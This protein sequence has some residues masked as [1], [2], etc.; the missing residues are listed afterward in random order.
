M[1]PEWCTIATFSWF[2][3]SI[4]FR[5]SKAKL[6]KT[7]ETTRL[8][9][10][11]LCSHPVTRPHGRCA[12]PQQ[13]LSQLRMLSP[14]PSLRS[15]PPPSTAVVMVTGGKGRSCDGHVLLRPDLLSPN[16]LRGHYPG[17]TFQNGP[18]TTRIDSH[19]N[20][21]AESCLPA[22]LRLMS[23][24]EGKVAI[25][26]SYCNQYWHQKLTLKYAKLTL[27]CYG[28]FQHNRAEK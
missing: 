25:Y 26:V 2:P 19:V 20:H 6:Q 23:F 7:W 13:H 4:K 27:R 10:C 18:T 15:P 16:K 17:S 8:C 5:M 1:E 22:S 11:S 12:N 28:P 24:Y 3:A 14:P 9:R 21:R